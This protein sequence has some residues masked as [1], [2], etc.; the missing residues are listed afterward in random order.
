MTVQT[1]NDGLRSNL[2]R[3]WYR[4]FL[5]VPS[6]VLLRTHASIA[7]ILNV[8]PAHEF[9]PKI[10]PNMY[11]WFYRPRLD[12]RTKAIPVKL[13]MWL[14]K[15]QSPQSPNYTQISNLPTQESVIISSQNTGRA[16]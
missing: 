15:Q 16:D 1:K 2:I 7:K 14:S 9:P 12:S 8:S 4:G 3:V 13:L 10:F 6:P 5:S 11:K